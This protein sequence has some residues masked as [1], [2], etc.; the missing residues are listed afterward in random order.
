MIS[1]IDDITHKLEKKPEVARVLLFGSRARVD[2]DAR[3]DIDLAIDCPAASREQWQRIREEVDRTRTL[4][5]ID[6]VRF[7]TAPQSLRDRILEEG[8]VL[9]ER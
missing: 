1:A 2:H 9:Y 3:S 5:F 8:I 6:V 4:L 7:D